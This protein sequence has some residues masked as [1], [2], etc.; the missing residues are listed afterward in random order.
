M[1]S[2][3]VKPATHCRAANNAFFVAACLDFRGFKPW[4]SDCAIYNIKVASLV[5]VERLLMG[6]WLPCFRECGPR[7]FVIQEVVNPVA[8][9]A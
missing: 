4:R 2:G 1:V 9:A 7:V 5:L 6:F 3:T 8:V